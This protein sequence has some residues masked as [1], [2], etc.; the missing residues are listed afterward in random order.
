MTGGFAQ[1]L[2]DVGGSLAIVQQTY[3]LTQIE[4]GVSGLAQYPFSRVQRFEV[5]GGLRR[6]SFDQDIETEQYS[7]VSGQRIGRFTE[8]G[9]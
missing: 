8:E 6:I 5:A 7:A 1:G 4:R 2:A 9:L 3:R